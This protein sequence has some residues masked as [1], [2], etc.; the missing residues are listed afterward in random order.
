MNG[1]DDGKVVVP[2]DT[3][4]SDL[5]RRIQ[6]PLDEDDHMPP[7]GKPQLTADEI[8][9]LKWWI[10]AGAPEKKMLAELQPP[11]EILKIVSSNSMPAALSK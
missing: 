1:G 11:A 2:G 4:H 10:D 9:L 8:A 3:A 5:P 7:D 6:L